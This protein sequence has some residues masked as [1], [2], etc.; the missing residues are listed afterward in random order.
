TEDVR[1]GSGRRA[2]QAPARPKLSSR[3]GR[4]RA[5][6]RREVSAHVLRAFASSILADPAVE[7]PRAAALDV[8][9]IRGRGWAVVELNSAWAAGL[10]GCDPEAVL[11]VLRH[12]SGPIR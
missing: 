12:A 6:R 2:S 5:A 3:A 1:R 11:E 7:V 8:G 10:Y 4:T 9:R